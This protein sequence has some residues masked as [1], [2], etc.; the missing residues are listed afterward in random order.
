MEDKIILFR[1]FENSIDANIIK[2]KLDAFDIPCFLTQENMANLYPGA[3]YHIGSFSVR[4]F[5]FQGDVEK[6]VQVLEENH[7]HL[8]DDSI[9]M[10]PHCRSRK[11]D[12]DFANKFPLNFIKIITVFF[13]FTFPVSRVYR[14]LDCEREF[15]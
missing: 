12:K 10:C 6:A 11:V 4:L 14:C 7:L 3:G 5:I 13:G 1:E 9:T 8:D 15:N 2:T